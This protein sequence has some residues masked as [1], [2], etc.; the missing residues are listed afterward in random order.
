M[1]GCQGGGVW[2]DSDS[3]GMRGGSGGREG[4]RGNVNRVR[5]IGIGESLLVVHAVVAWGEAT[6]TGKGGGG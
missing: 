1:G 3:K 6:K 4:R 2:R 5:Y